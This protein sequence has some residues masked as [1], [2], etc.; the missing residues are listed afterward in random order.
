VRCGGRS[1]CERSRCV[2]GGPDSVPLPLSA[3]TSRTGTRGGGSAGSQCRT[4]TPA[5][6][7]TQDAAGEPSHVARRSTSRVGLVVASESSSRGHCLSKGHRPSEARPPI[8][9]S[10]PIAHRIAHLNLDP[11]RK[12]I[13]H[14]KL[15]TRSPIARTGV[16]TGH[17]GGRPRCKRRAG[18]RKN[19]ATSA[20]D[21]VMQSARECSNDA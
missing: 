20:R 4:S 1:L 6:A 11:R 15:D 16:Y 10:S 14:R 7:A 17:R 3:V 2:G 21:S 18:T 19:P 12:L 8:T 13:A 5:Q 9:R